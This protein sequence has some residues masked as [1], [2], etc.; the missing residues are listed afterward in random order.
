VALLVTTALE[1]SWGEHEPLVFLGEW[2]RRYE[3]AAAWRVCEHGVVRNHWDDRIK[4]R[5]DHDYL[6][7]LHDELFEDLVAILGHLHGIDRPRRFWR[8]LLDPWLTRYL[9]VAFDRW[10]NL[11]T[12]FD[13]HR[14]SGTIVRTDPPLVA[15]CGHLQ[16]HELVARDDWNHDFYAAILRYQ[17]ADRCVLRERGMPWGGEDTSAVKGVSSVLWKTM[18]RLLRTADGVAGAL[19]RRNR[20]L[21][22][23]S[24]FPLAAL[25][26]LNLRLRQVPSLLLNEFAWPDRRFQSDKTDWALRERIS[27]HRTPRNR[28]ETFLAGRLRSDLPQVLVESFGSMRKQT[29]AI[30]LRPKV[31]VSANAHFFNDLFKHWIAEQVNRGVSLVT[32]DHGGSLHPAFGLMDFE[33]DISE[34]KATWT[35]PYHPKHIQMPPTKIAG[36]RRFTPR[37]KRLLIIGMEMPRYASA[38]WSGPIGAQSLVGFEDVCRLHDTLSEAPQRAVLV[39]PYP[40]Q[41]WCTHQRFVERLGPRKVS[42]S[43]RLDTVIR[44][45]RLIVCTYPQ[46]TFSEAMA[47]G[48]P[49]LLVYPRHLWETVSLFEPLVDLLHE[50]GM[51]FFD[52]RSAADH[53]NRIWEDP[54]TWW[55]SRPVRAAR[56]RF[57]AEILNLGDDWLGPWVAFATRMAASA[58][59][60]NDFRQRAA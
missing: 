34:V 20:V 41:G 55:Q 1:W 36:R 18:T 37:G 22:V 8:I 10:E 9:G 39:K 49:T 23:S 21:F 43:R 24:Y 40:N 29:E 52:P 15:P 33:E 35:R 30:R 60:T 4:L 45:A 51:V 5:R 28:F 57:E 50:E 17:Y 31:V 56:A 27:V 26:S 46:T 48:A 7:S 3:R 44:A 25:V 47:S 12:V 38:A 53:I 2:C 32:V 14:I 59:P 58:V 16:F 6:R 13:E 19:S 11:R 54:L 42:S